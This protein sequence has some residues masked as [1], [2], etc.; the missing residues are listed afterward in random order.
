M[1]RT[2]KAY[3]KKAAF[4]Q[5]DFIFFEHGIW[6]K[7]GR[8]EKKLNREAAQDLPATCFYRRIQPLS[9]NYM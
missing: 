9:N 5:E 6:M 1:S 7:R 3:G 2:L 8:I 4:K